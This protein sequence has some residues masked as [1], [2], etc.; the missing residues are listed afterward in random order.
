M[1]AV[2]LNAYVFYNNHLTLA[3]LALYLPIVLIV[4]SI[5]YAAI[6]Q[7]VIRLAHRR[8]RFSATRQRVPSPSAAG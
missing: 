7:P 3:R 5:T 4:S 8:I 1:H 2:V 6:E